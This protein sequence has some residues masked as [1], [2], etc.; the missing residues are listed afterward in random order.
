MYKSAHDSVTLFV[1][2][3]HASHFW[4]E[5]RLSSHGKYSRRVFNVKFGVWYFAHSLLHFDV[6]LNMLFVTQ[7]PW[8]DQ[9]IFFCEPY[10]Q[11]TWDGCEHQISIPHSL[12]NRGVS[13]KVTWLH[14]S[15][16][17]YISSIHVGYSCT[18]VVLHAHTY[19]H[20]ALGYHDMGL[21]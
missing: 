14:H 4:H 20:L 3:M 8:R 1:C 18:Y 5:S 12:S 11:I 17:I 10:H 19:I 13:S 2:E 16:C 21:G 15:S 9:A 7:M 6:N